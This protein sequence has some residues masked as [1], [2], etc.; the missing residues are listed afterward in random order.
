MKSF[1][2]AS[3]A[4]LAATTVASAAVPVGVDG[5][6]GGEWTGVTTKTVTHADVAPESNFALPT[7]LTTGA[8]YDVRVRNDA[9]FYYVAAEITGAAGLS[10]GNFANLYLDLNPAA[11]SGGSELLFEV[12]TNGVRAF[13]AGG[14]E[15]A[16]A[17]PYT[18]SAVGSGVVEFAISNLFLQ[19][20]MAQV[21][22]TNNTV[23]VRM[24]QA[25]GYSVG[26]G[27]LYGPDRLGIAAVPEPTTLAAI[28]GGAVLLLGRRRR[29]A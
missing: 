25:F 12:G 23:A 22:E 1:A 5:T 16:Y 27:E 26:G 6:I 21:G 18:A 29:R 9:D 20:A 10:A 19:G 17:V 8:T 7:P 28:A 14:P 15:I 24:S 11:L 13:I 3:I 2:I 4:V